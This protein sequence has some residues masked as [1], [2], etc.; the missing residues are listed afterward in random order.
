MDCC[1]IIVIILIAVAILLYFSFTDKDTSI[2]GGH[3][4]KHNGKTL[5][6]ENY[7]KLKA[8][9]G[10]LNPKWKS[11]QI[12]EEADR[13]VKELLAKMD[14]TLDYHDQAKYIDDSIAEY[15]KSLNSNQPSIN[16]Q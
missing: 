5:H 1:V 10:E 15:I 13:I 11:E 4:V 2:Y 6:I 12:R 7:K 9:L 8:K 3:E 14:P 16:N